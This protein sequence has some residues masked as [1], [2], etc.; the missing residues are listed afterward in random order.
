MTEEKEVK[1]KSKFWTVFD[2]VGKNLSNSIGIGRTKEEKLAMLDN[3]VEIEKRKV[4][5]AML[6]AKARQA[7]GKYNETNQQ[8]GFLNPSEDVIKMAREW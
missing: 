6:K 8:G 7:N 2:R 5:L 1:K 3:Q 4:A